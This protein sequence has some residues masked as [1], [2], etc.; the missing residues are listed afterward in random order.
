MTGT[1]EDSSEEEHV[2]SLWDVLDSNPNTVKVLSGWLS[3]YSHF[4]LLF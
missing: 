4:L 3:A 2:N 1:G